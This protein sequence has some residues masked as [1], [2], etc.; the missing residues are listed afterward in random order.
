MNTLSL[1][2]LPTNTNTN[3]NT[4]ILIYI[5]IY[6]AAEIWLKK[7]NIEEVLIAKRWSWLGFKVI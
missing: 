6:V 4:N 7:T 1:P 5:L 3:T 2:V